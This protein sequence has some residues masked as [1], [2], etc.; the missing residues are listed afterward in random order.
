MDPA[1]R[2]LDAA[3]VVPR[4]GQ[5]A[6]RP[7][8]AQHQ[9]YGRPSLGKET[10]S[11]PCSA[12]LKPR[13]LKYVQKKAKRWPSPQ[14]PSG[15]RAGPCTAA[16]HRRG[17]WRGDPRPGTMTVYSAD[18]KPNPLWFLIGIWAKLI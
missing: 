16:S 13:V 3:L 15:L 18:H 1:P 10:K 14:E 5:S 9:F 17:T 11:S 8:P 12:K 6:L 4:P 7:E 2:G